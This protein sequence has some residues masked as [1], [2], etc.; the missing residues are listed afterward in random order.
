MLDATRDLRFAL[1]GGSLATLAGG[2]LGEYMQVF[3]LAISVLW[4]WVRVTRA[5]RDAMLVA[6]RWL[7]PNIELTRFPHPRPH[8]RSR[9][10]SRPRP[11]PR[12][13]RHRHCRRSDRIP[14]Y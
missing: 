13:R 4:C 11:R 7:A 1:V 5:G 3:A 12:R 8:P 9:S 14:S 10:R 2:A 6:E